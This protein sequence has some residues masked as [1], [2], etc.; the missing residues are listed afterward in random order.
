M[1]WKKR[2]TP[3]LFFWFVHVWL[4]FCWLGILIVIQFNV[5]IFLYYLTY[6]LRNIDAKTD[7]VIYPISSI[8]I[9]AACWTGNKIQGKV[10]EV[11]Q[12]IKGGWIIK[13]QIIGFLIFQ[14]IYAFII[15][16][17]YRLTLFRMA[18]SVSLQL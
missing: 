17:I 2:M 6:M 11:P 16:A 18:Y 8:N 15:F 7:K 10:F 5:H 4:Y 14:L 9:F 13:Y 3:I 12:A 1:T